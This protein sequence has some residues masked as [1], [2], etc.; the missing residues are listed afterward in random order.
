ML[1]TFIHWALPFVMGGVVTA[2][3]KNYKENKTIK[4]AIL[5][6]VRFDIVKL[7]EQAQENG[8]LSEYGRISLESLRTQYKVLGGNHGIEVLIDKTFNL[9]LK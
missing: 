1:E 7:C 3:T 5:S 9:P 6:L 8:Y 4:S 2:I